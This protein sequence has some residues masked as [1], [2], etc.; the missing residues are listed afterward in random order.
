MHRMHVFLMFCLASQ[1][2]HMTFLD[3]AQLCYVMLIICAL[4]INCRYDSKPVKQSRNNTNAVLGCNLLWSFSRYGWDKSRYGWDKL[5]WCPY[6]TD[7]SHM[8]YPWNK[9]MR[10]MIKEN[11][12]DIKSHYAWSSCIEWHIIG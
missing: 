9:I 2:A 1:L 8:N 12:D 5:Y 6:Q 7:Y 10:T 4:N 11:N 3:N